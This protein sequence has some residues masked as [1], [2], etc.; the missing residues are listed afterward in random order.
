MMNRQHTDCL[1]EWESRPRREWETPFHDEEDH[2]TV[3]EER[4]EAIKQQAWDAEYEQTLE[5]IADESHIQV[6]GLPPKK[7]KAFED[8][9]NKKLAK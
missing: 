8:A 3:D 7:A 6:L 1:A 2:E 4:R 5:I 9:L